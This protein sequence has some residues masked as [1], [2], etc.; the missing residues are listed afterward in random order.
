MRLRRSR[1]KR[2]QK[3][4]DA[5]AVSAAAVDFV[6]RVARLPT[7]DEKVPG[8][9]LG[10]LPGGTMANFACAL[11]RL[12]RKVAWM[13]T[14]GDDQDGELVRRDFR[15]FGVDT[16]HVRVARGQTT[17]FTVI[18]LGRSA[19]KGIV[20]VPTLREAIPIGP[21]LLRYLARAHYIYLSPH[22]RTLFRRMALAVRSAGSRL[23][24]EV[25]PTAGLTLARGHWVLRLSH[26]VVSNRAGLEA[27]I[28]AATP[29]SRQALVE[30]ARRLQAVG[31]EIVAVTLGR[32]GAILLR[33]G[34]TV[35]QPGFRVKAVDT[36]GAGDCFS[37]ALLFGLN[38]G[39]PL[40][41]IGAYANAAAALSTTALGPR[42][43]LP[44]DREVRAFLRR[45]GIGLT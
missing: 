13:G 31:P 33:G 3:V 34:E 22:D 15:R 25:E 45:H 2:V 28:G 41:T 11:S 12:G 23:A 5:I 18:F 35:Y 16:T 43:H 8:R 14:V 38:R 4:F 6:I 24:L 20:V 29:L 42:G 19:E 26:V 40:G 10:R 27:F 17:S 1:G 37:A 30:E 21:R 7:L 9:L 39:W 36:T 44:T 32:E